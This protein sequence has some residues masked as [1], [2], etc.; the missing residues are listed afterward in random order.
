MN[1]IPTPGID[2]IAFD[3]EIKGDAYLKEDR[4]PYGD[5]V[6]ADDARRLEKELAE[7]RAW[8]ES[9]QRDYMICQSGNTK[10]QQTISAQSARIAELEG[11]LNDIE[12]GPP[13]N[14]PDY[15]RGITE[16]EIA[17]KALTQPP[18]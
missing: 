5:Y 16:K 6:K 10:L 7:L 3:I 4:N 9:F 11:A 1:E 2:A 14:D 13:Y 17:R 8:K 18:V 15:E 12:S